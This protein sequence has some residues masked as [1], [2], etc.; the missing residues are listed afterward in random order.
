MNE[1]VLFSIRYCWGFY[2]GSELWS[3]DF[4]ENKYASVNSNTLMLI[5]HPL[6]R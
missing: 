4:A 2:D 5:A 3:L 6:I 1:N